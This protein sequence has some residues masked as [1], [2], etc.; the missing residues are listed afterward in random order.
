MI[1]VSVSGGKKVFEL[2]FPDWGRK[3]NWSAGEQCCNSD[4][5]CVELVSSRAPSRIFFLILISVATSPKPEGELVIKEEQPEDLSI[6][7][8]ESFHHS[9]EILQSF[10]PR[11]TPSMPRVL[12]H[13]FQR[14]TCLSSILPMIEK[15]ILSMFFPRQPCR[16][17]LNCQCYQF[18]PQCLL[19]A[20]F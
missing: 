17:C 6:V 20:H 11:H 3:T 16:H 15:N 5:A 4:H 13:I 9:L 8:G 12:C 7:S 14:R 19:I 10:L 18:S 1:S 2:D